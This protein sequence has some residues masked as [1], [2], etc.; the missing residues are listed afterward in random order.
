MPSRPPARL[1]IAR[2]FESD[3]FLHWTP[4]RPLFLTLESDEPG[5]QFYSS[6][7]F[8]YESMYLGLL[9]CYRS[10]STHQV[11]FQLVS[12]RDGVHWDRAANRQPFIDN[13]PVGS[14][15]GGYH[16]DFSN[17]PIRMG[18]EL[19]FYYGST[20]F[21]KNV[22]PYKGGICLAKL[23]LDGFASFDAGERA[24]TL[25]T[26]PLDFAGGARSLTINCLAR[27]AGSIRVEVTDRHQQPVPGFGLEDAAPITADA[28]A[29]KVKWRNHGDLSALDGRTIRLRF[30]LR[31]ASLYSFAIRE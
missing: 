30:H 21:G 17:P 14:L 15:D 28:V 8:N 26:R 2:H 3:D 24:G 6:T 23:R 10:A 4:P 19:W 31:D 18:N 29:E 27:R 7:G 13:G 16:S 11:Y 22:R 25:L 5:L 1:A 20:E 9:R 12:S